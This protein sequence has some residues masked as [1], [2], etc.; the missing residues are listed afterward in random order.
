MAGSRIKLDCVA[1]GTQPI[2]YRWTRNGKALSHVKYKAYGPSL[3]INKLILDDAGN[4][5]C[6][7]SNV[8]GNSNCSYEVKVYGLYLSLSL[9]LLIIYCFYFY[10]NCLSYS[11]VTRYS[12]FISFLCIICVCLFLVATVFTINLNILFS[13]S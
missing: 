9:S 1:Q 2:V 5:T 7:A 6:V 3:K 10:Y 13:L 12:C 8:F 4:Y 11:D